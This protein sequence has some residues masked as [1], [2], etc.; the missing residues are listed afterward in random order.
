MS[1]EWFKFLLA[2]LYGLYLYRHNR[3]INLRLTRNVKLGTVYNITFF[4]TLTVQISFIRILYK[5]AYNQF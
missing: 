3:H 1:A 2:L 5:L 4:D